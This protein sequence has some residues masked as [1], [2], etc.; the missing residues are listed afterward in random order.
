[1]AMFPLVDERSSSRYSDEKR[2]RDN[3]GVK[4]PQQSGSPFRSMG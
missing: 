2:E 4:K 3:K 1:M